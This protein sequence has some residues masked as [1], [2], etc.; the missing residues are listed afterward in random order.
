M[1]CIDS[2]FSHMLRRN[3]NLMS[4]AH[5][6]LFTMSLQIK[7]KNHQYKYN[8]KSRWGMFGIQVGILNKKYYLNNIQHHI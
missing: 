8:K 6:F 7:D 2:Q 3:L 5:I 1:K 4:K